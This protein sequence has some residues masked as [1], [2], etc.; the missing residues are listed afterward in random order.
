MRSLVLFAA[1]LVSLK[2]ISNLIYNW[3]FM[4]QP[5]ATRKLTRRWL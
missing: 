2:L 1:A 4:A 3:R 5:E